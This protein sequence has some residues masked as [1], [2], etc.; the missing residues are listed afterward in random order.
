[1]SANNVRLRDCVI[2]S[3]DG[4][5][6]DVE[7]SFDLVTGNKIAGNGTYGVL[8]GG[9]HNTVA[10][11]ILVNNDSGAAFV[12]PLKDIGTANRVG[13]FVGDASITATNPWSN[14]VY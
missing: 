2:D 6:L 4:I 9:D 1:M 11:N 10:S 5:G 14:V 3:N 8:L 13:T 7:G 12:Q